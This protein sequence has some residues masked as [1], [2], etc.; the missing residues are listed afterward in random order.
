MQ[1]GDDTESA[2]Q[3]TAVMSNKQICPLKIAVA[4]SLLCAAVHTCMAKS[5]LHSAA[6]CRVSEADMQHL[7]AAARQAKHALSTA[8]SVSLQLP[9]S[10]E[11]P[12]RHVPVTRQQFEDMS[13]PLLQRL[14][15]PLDILAASTKL[16]W[17]HSGSE[18]H[19][20][21]TTARRD[22]FA[23]PPR[24]ISDLVLVGGQDTVPLSYL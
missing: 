9:A 2:T 7:T 21:W 22:R 10:L 17:A 14:M 16:E 1:S 23:P 18:H 11:T 8:Q 6:S 3:L 15:E 5:R 20:T 13:R 19:S 4:D 24:R 12:Y